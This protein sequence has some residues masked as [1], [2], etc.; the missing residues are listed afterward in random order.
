M[1]FHADHP[2]VFVGLE[3]ATREAI[4]AGRKR[5][6]IRLLWERM[7]WTMFIEHGRDEFKMNDHFHSRYVRLLIERHPEWREMFELRPLRA[8]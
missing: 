6:G 5:I 8:V 2:E 1:A 3:R 4:A 7:R